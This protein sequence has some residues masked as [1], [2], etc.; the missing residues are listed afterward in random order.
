MTGL[1]LASTLRARVAA[2]AAKQ[3][4]IKEL[5]LR[6]RRL[7]MTRRASQSSGKPQLSMVSD[8]EAID[9][10]SLVAPSFAWLNSQDRNLTYD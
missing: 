3:I 9:V 1:Q 7:C 4:C 2:T 6:P 10:F 5:L 8:S